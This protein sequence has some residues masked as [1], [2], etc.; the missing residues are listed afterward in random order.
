MRFPGS[1]FFLF[2]PFFHTLIFLEGR[3][4]SFFHLFIF[5]FSFSRSNDAGGVFVMVF[6]ALAFS[7]GECSSRLATS[8][9]ADRQRVQQPT[10]VSSAMTSWVSTTLS[11]LSVY[12]KVARLLKKRGRLCLLLVRVAI[13]IAIFFLFFFTLF[14]GGGGLEVQFSTNIDM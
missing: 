13:R 6:F 1:T 7:R 3:F 10:G 5:L 14:L 9:A 11:G 12:S 4:F 8:A 2:L